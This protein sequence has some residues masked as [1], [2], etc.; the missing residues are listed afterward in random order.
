MVLVKAGKLLH[1][2][3]TS[4][5]ALA[6]LYRLRSVKPILIT[7]IV[8]VVSAA[9]QYEIGI[10]SPFIDCPFMG[11][12]I[13]IVDPIAVGTATHGNQKGIIIHLTDRSDG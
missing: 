10:V 13:E 6:C 2:V 9:F 7:K 3:L 11:G 1:S 12:E 5:D 8:D 4:G